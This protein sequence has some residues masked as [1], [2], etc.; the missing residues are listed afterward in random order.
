VDK[1]P[2][3]TLNFDKNVKDQK[4]YGLDKIHLNNSV[5]D[6][7]LISEQFCRE[8][9]NLVGIPTPRACNVR[10]ELNGKDL[11]MYVLV[12]G[13]NKTF[14]KQ[15]FKNTKGNLYDGG[16][17][18]DIENTLETQSGENQKDQSDR[19]AL[20]EAAKEKDLKERWKKL[21]EV[22]DTESFARFLALDC[23]LWHWDGYS[24]NVNNYRIFNNR[25]TGKL[26]F[27][28]HGLDQMF[29]K[30]E[31]PLF[32]GGQA[33]VTRHFLDI[34]EAKKLYFRTVGEILEKHFTPEFITNRLQQ[35]SGKLIAELETID[36]NLAS[37]KRG[38]VSSFQESALKRREHLME[39]MQI[40]SRVMKFSSDGTSKITNWVAKTDFGAPQLDRKVADGKT[41]VLHI[42]GT[43]TFVGSFRAKVVLESGT[44]RIEG[45]AKSAQVQADP[46]DKRSGGGIRV[47]NKRLDKKLLGTTEWSPIQFEFQVNE[48]FGEVELVCELR[49]AQGE[50]WF[51]E[52]S[53][54]LI[55]L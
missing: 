40:P 15:H 27:M 39:Q 11:G 36:K 33:L 32:F 29:E 3:L 18:R 24:M 9:Y 5:Q 6:S 44:Y 19:I 17:V 54:K 50:I 42:S 26:M 37:E 35:I 16:F 46:G 47:S 28:P 31:A 53:L 21:Q 14:L 1:N 22:L 52:D 30:P 7:T 10:V 12:E 20:V 8:L 49:A 34:P 13:Y 4:F 23:I 48:L 2:A 41:K 45:R 25:D 55:K 51:D 43:K 38:K